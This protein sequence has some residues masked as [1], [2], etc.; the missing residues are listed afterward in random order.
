MKI[1][2]KNILFIFLSFVKISCLKSSP[3][4]FEFVKNSLK[5]ISNSEPSYDWINKHF[6]GDDVIEII[7]GNE[8]RKKEV[9]ELKLNEYTSKFLIIEIFFSSFTSLNTLHVSCNKEEQISWVEE[10]SNEI[11]IE[12][13]SVLEFS[14]YASKILMKLKENIKIGILLVL[15]NKEDH[16]SWITSKSKELEIKEVGKLYLNYYAIDI[17][18][19]FKTKVILKTMKMSFYDI[20][21]KRF[22]ALLKEDVFSL[23]NE[24]KKETIMK[25]IGEMLEDNVFSLKKAQEIKALLLYNDIRYFNCQIF[26]FTI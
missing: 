8:I 16:I 17:L 26:M 25:M 24:E 13:I 18:K 2:L 5:I 3:V 12:K 19:I 11:Q 4:S 6:Q 9:K 21:E 10:E 15:C 14:N 1:K 22:I 7:K 20:E 23:L